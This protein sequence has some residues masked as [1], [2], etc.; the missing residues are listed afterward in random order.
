MIRAPWA[1]ANFKWV[2]NDGP[3]VVTL[4]NY[5]GNQV[6]IG[7]LYLPKVAVAI[8][9]SASPTPPGGNPFYTATPPFGGTNPQTIPMPAGTTQ[10]SLTATSP[11]T[12]YVY[13]ASGIYRPLM[14]GSSII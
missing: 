1:I 7:S 3:L 5:L 2:P 4:L 10:V 13:A 8:E 14:E 11:D 9:F 12:Y 6:A